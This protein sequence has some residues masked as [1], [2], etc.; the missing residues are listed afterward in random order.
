ML[1]C[2]RTAGELLRFAKDGG[3]SL[4]HASDGVQVL[5]GEELD[6]LFDSLFYYISMNVAERVQRIVTMSQYTFTNVQTQRL[7]ITRFLQLAVG[8]AGSMNYKHL[9]ETMQLLI[10]AL[11]RLP[12]TLANDKWNRA[13]QNM[14]YELFHA[15]LEWRWLLLLLAKETQKLK[16]EMQMTESTDTQ[17]AAPKNT[18]SEKPESED[19][20]KL[21]YRQMMID[22][23]NLVFQRFPINDKLQEIVG[24][25]PNQCQCF[26]LV[27]LGMMALAEQSDGKESFWGCLHDSVP[28]VISDSGIRYLF[29]LWLINS[30]AELCNESIFRQK[31]ATG[32]SLEALAPNPAIIDKVLEEAVKIDYTEQQMRIVLLL[33]IPVVTDLWPVWSD[34][35]SAVW[36]YFA[37]RLNSQFLLNAESVANSA[38]A[39]SS[40]LSFIEKAQA[41]AVK[42]KVFPRLGFETDSLRMFI[43]L[44]TF[45]I[46]HYTDEAN[47]RKVQIIFNRT[48]IG[49]SPNRYNSMTEQAIYNLGLLITAMINATSFKEDYPRVSKHLQMIPLTGGLIDSSVDVTIRRIVMATQ[50]H[51]AVLVRFGS[52]DY[53]KTAHLQGFLKRFGEALEKY[54]KR[55]LPA[56]TLMAEGMLLLYKQAEERGSYLLGE[57]CLIDSWLEK[58]LLWTQTGWYKQ[59]NAIAT[60]MQVAATTEQFTPAI[61]QHIYPFVKQQY[62]RTRP[63]APCISHIAAS[64]TISAGSKFNNFFETF[65]LC[66]TA[67]PEQRLEYVTRVAMSTRLVELNEEDVIK[68]WLRL[69]MVYDN[70]KMRKFS[71]IVCQMD[72]FQALCEIPECDLLNSNAMPINLF[73][74]SVRERYR[75]TR[76]N[77]KSEVQIKFNQLFRNVGT[78]MPETGV[79]LRQ[80]FL[81][82]LVSALSEC[83]EIFYDRSCAGC[84]YNIAFYHYFLPPT[85][86]TE[87]DIPL[88]YIEAIAKVWLQVL[89]VLS[90]MEYTTDPLVKDN[91]RLMFIKWL[92]QF[93]KLHTS[94][95]K[96][97]PLVQ[98]FCCANETIVRRGMVWVRN[99][100]VKYKAEKLNASKRQGMLMVQRLL[101]TL[102]K[103]KKHDKLAL[104]I[105]LFGY[106]LLEHAFNSQEY[107]AERSW[108]IPI[109]MVYEIL[110]CTGPFGVVHQAMRDALNKFTCKYLPDGHSA[111]F[112]FMQKLTDKNPGFIRLTVDMLREDL[113]NSGRLTERDQIL[114]NKLPYL[115]TEIAEKVINQKVYDVEF[116]ESFDGV[117]SEDEF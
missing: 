34:I 58:Y 13:K 42:G 90:Q 92:P 38:C 17:S 41:V 44:I 6:Q 96:L 111:F 76:V 24:H 21:L 71:Q 43:A 101:D 53:N 7:E 22:L 31:S 60:G 75:K 2:R 102:I 64:V 70:I 59:L 93:T 25:S 100:F 37:S 116:D 52:S 40:V 48:V 18:D 69:A 87:Q 108:E 103:I 26:C 88:E 54:G 85:V 98:F 80:R 91:F 68:L 19:V 89:E 36:K 57:I 78:W 4:C 10:G 12:H 3:R 65:T 114:R 117:L 66:R 51:M 63:A 62:S 8:S 109:K 84:M 77:E 27:W 67:H 72:Q 97:H 94:A 61:M 11:P 28:L 107:E 110:A 45:T 73:F 14:S 104:F 46:R 9:N 56:L 50:V 1:N 55:L 106:L 86:Q 15:I 35:V 82:A 113:I 47:K 115:Q 81:E 20:F 5:L 32:K 95:D 79:V 99:E 112:V 23:L 33:L 29:E 74:R 83:H 16:G 30:L 105:K 49:L 39:S